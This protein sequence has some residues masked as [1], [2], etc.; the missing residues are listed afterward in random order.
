MKPGLL[1]AFLLVLPVVAATV[2]TTT[3]AP[4]SARVGDWVTLSYTKTAAST[5]GLQNGS[6]TPTITGPVN[7]TLA[8]APYRF[9]STSALNYASATLT[10]TWQPTRAG[11]YT[12]AFADHALFGHAL[13]AQRSIQVQD[14]ETQTGGTGQVARQPW[15]APYAIL[16]GL[17]AGVLVAL[18]SI[19]LPN[20]LTKRGRI[21][22]GASLGV[23]LLGLIL[24]L[25]GRLA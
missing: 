4:S 1:L 24:V 3:Q 14:N 10:W 20:S 17:V 5:D 9:Q 11:N 18:G 6:I 25:C 7:V 15:H 22:A 21:L 13:N 2:T 8:S 19:A 12:V 16:V 23:L